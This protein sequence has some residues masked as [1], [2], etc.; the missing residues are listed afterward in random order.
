M[1]QT[2]NIVLI[3]FMGTGKSAVG[4]VLARRLGW[5]H[6]DTDAEIERQAGRMIPE[7]F[8]AEGE[9]AFRAR[10][11]ALLDSLA[12]PLLGAG[13]SSLAPP[14][15]TGKGAGGLGFD[16]DL[17]LSTG[18]GTPLRPENAA[19]LKRIGTVV[20][21]HVAPEAILARVAK[22]LHERPL[23][24]GHR[25]DPL[26]RIQRLLADRVPRYAALA[27]YT[28]DTSDCADSEEAAGR[29]LRLLALPIP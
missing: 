2:Q 1:P 4:R 5:R 3:G 25:D 28:L 10:E 12:P 17:I 11:S 24:A 16:G 20:W 21:L 7:I 19:L 26:G 23:L 22:S 9:A 27:D 14:S 15:L 29:L 13:G 8:T 18:G 6:L